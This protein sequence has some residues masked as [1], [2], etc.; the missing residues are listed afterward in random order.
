MEQ[1]ILDGRSLIR[2]RDPEKCSFASDDV[3]AAILHRDP[4]QRVFT[5]MLLSPSHCAVEG[6]DLVFTF[7]CS[8]T[9]EGTFV[10][11]EGEDRTGCF[12]FVRMAGPSAQPWYDRDHAPD[13][14][15]PQPYA[16]ATCTLR[17]FVGHALVDELL[18]FEFVVGAGVVPQA[19]EEAVLG[20]T[21]GSQA[22]FLVDPAC[23][24]RENGNPR[25]SVAG[26][27]IPENAVTS[28]HVELLA[29]QNPLTDFEKLQ[30]AT[31]VKDDGNRQV[32]DSE[33]AAAA[34]SYQRALRILTSS[35]GPAANDESSQAD[36]KMQLRAL[37]VTLLHNLAVAIAS[38]DSISARVAAAAA[39]HCSRALAIDPN[40]AKSRFRRALCLAQ[41]REWDR[42]LEDVRYLEAN[43][44]GDPV[45]T[46]ALRERIETERRGG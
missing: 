20:M 39:A 36:V 40:H 6:C 37:K 13:A 35:G 8:C 17:W 26:Q 23:G 3:K 22:V 1:W 15:C 45:A 11:A 16:E 41:Q 44:L 42:A 43:S 14:R 24:F 19:A 25:P 27:T 10:T 38:Q 32:A 46:A 21:V 4:A 34:T 12:G 31:T 30:R 2:Q 7:G 9:G 29:F 28:L 18:E 33:F 5:S